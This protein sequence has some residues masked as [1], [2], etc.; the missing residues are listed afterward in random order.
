METYR[1]LTVRP[2][3]TWSSLISTHGSATKWR[4]LPFPPRLGD[5]LVL[6][7]HTFPTSPT[8]VE[9]IKVANELSWLWVLVDH[10]KQAWSL[11]QILSECKPLWGWPR[12]LSLVPPHSPRG[13]DGPAREERGESAGGKPGYW[14][15]QPPCKINQRSWS[16]TPWIIT[17]RLQHPF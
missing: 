12:R 15:K 17:V 4:Q 14:S 5:I 10:R 8:Q 1:R 11:P 6:R 16:E 3:H 2:S 7:N 9:S 13:A